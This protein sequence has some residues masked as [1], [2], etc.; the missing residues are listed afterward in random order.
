[1]TRLLCLLALVLLAAAPPQRALAHALEPGY[2]ELEHLGGEDW[3]VIW[4]KPQANGRPMP[5]DAV[6]PETCTPRRGGAPVFDGRGF[7]AGWV[8]HCPGGLVGGRIRIEGLERTRTDVLLRYTLGPDSPSQAAR[9]T[10]SATAFAVPAPL[11]MLQIAQGYFGLG[12][13]HILL[14]FDHLAFVFLLI[15]MIR[16][17]RRLVASITA[18]TVAHSL[19]LAAASL[20]LIAVPAPP[21]EAVVALSI[22]MLAAELL[23]P[24]GQAPGLTRR[25]PWIVIFC[26]G[27]LHGLGFA[28]ALREIGLP[29]GDVP[30]ALLAFNLG[31]EAGQL[32][33]IATVMTLAAVAGLAV[34]ALRRTLRD[35]RSAMLRDLARAIG[36]LAA[37]WMIDRIALFLA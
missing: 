34:P 36:S 22:M 24:E 9:L 20:G 23:Q 28:N 32:L 2:L 27:L 13:D 17:M 37:F 33:F 18:F 16:D 8:A 15:L 11:T 7:V 10:A 1:M 26:F 4:R 25:Y 12:V 30:L 14:G 5:I 35:P 29:Q 21:V 31:V 3:R 19:S 6:L